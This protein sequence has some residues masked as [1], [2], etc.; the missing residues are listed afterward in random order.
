[1]DDDL[2][3]IGQYDGCDVSITSSE[4]DDQSQSCVNKIPV[5]ISNRCKN[6]PKFV[7]RQRNNK[8]IK[9][10][11]KTLQAL[12]LPVVINL[13]PRSVYNKVNEFHSLVSELS[14]DLIFMSESWE[15]E[16]LTLDQIIDL[17]NYQVISN[18][19][20]RTGVGGR[21][22]LIIN[23]KKYHVENLTNTLVNIPHGVEITWA[24]LTPK[25]L[26]PSSII[27][28]IAV[29]SIYCK[30]SSRTKTKLLDH[31]AETYHMLNSKHLDGLHFILAGDTNDLK[32]D[33]ILSLSP[34]LRQVVNSATR[35]DKMID[36]IITTL[37]KYFQ[38]PVCLPPL[39]PDPDKNGAP[40]DH[41]IVYMRPIDSVNNNPARKLKIVRYRPLP[42]SGIREMGNW[43]VNHDWAEVF[44]ASTAHEKAFILQTT[45]LE[46]LDVF[47]PEKNVKFT[48][49][50]QVWITP[51]LK[52][53]SRKKQREFFKHRKSSKWRNLNK[54]FEEKS[55]LAKKSYYTN[56][57]EDLKNSH[58]GQWYSKLN[59]L[60]IHFPE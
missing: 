5:V 11:N 25:D 54:L 9:R 14:V 55:E 21:P 47:L 6:Q 24:M 16:S 31:I 10:S 53:I 27:K 17:E 58:P 1:M 18:V 15:R 22:A 26:S 34:N 35:G 36:P 37:S 20:Q 4:S 12:D 51:E 44:S 3:Q 2:L 60:Q 19:Y 30:P 42:E 29:A 13:N 59:G 57:V 46:K 8:T 33:S 41:M 7:N 43:I 28:K 38:S 48:S 32:L 45:L 49:E 23:D 40:A 52:D 56:I 39:D 50:D